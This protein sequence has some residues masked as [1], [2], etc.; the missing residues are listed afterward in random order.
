[1]LHQAT[2]MW[3]EIF[4]LIPEGFQ[5]QASDATRN[6]NDNKKD[7]TNPSATNPWVALNKN[8]ENA[9]QLLIQK[10]PDFILDVFRNRFVF[11]N[12]KTTNAF[13]QACTRVTTTRPRWLEELEECKFINLNTRVG[14]DKIFV[15][16]LLKR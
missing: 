5:S 6:S 3:K 14:T 1:M 13:C 8:G 2:Q 9:L 15:K 10:N 7:G 12:S 4:Y 11:P 16:K